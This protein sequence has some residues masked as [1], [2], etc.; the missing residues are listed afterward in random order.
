MER[1]DKSKARKSAEDAI[2][3]QV[4]ARDKRCRYPFCPMCRAYKNLPLEA[5]HVLQAKGMGGDKRLVRSQRHHLMLLDVETHR[6][7]ERH[8]IVIVP[9]D[10]H[11]GTD[12][13]CEFWA[14]DERGQLYLVAREL[15]PGGP[16][17]HD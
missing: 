11:L 1:R 2:K 6:R 12:G 14:E 16:Y 9:V 7:Q 13:P 17:E 4:R 8:A 15:A 3:D 5:A 10:A